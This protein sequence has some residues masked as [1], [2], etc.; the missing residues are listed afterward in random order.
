MVAFRGMVIGASLKQPRDVTVGLVE[1]WKCGAELWPRHS[2]DCR[3]GGASRSDHMLLFLFAN[4]GV[5]YLSVGF[6]FF[7]FF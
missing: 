4:V 1:Q 5:V 3:S 2:E 7:F 6:F